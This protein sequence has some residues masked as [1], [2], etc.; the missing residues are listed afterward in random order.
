M[1]QVVLPKHFL[2]Y[3]IHSEQRYFTELSDT[4][5][6][7]AINA[8]MLAHAPAALA[9][10]V[11]ASIPDKVFVVDPLTHAFQHDPVLL[12]R[13]VP[14]VP[15]KDATL[16]MSVAKMSTEL[17]EPIASKAGNQ[18]VNP[19]DFDDAS[20]RQE[21]CRRVL[22]FQQ[23]TLDLASRDDDYRDYLD[24]A[25]M[26]SMRP[27]IVIAPYFFMK[28][29]TLD[30][31]LPLNLSLL[32][33]AADLEDPV[34]AQVVLGKDV[35]PRLDLIEKIGESYGKSRCAGVC[36][37]I[38]DLDEHEADEDVL[39]GLST[40]VRRIVDYGKSVHNVY[41]GY[42]SQ[43]LVKHGGLSGVCHGLEYGES[44]SVVP[45]GG[46]IP[47]AKYYYPPLH[48]RLKFDSL[49]QILEQ[50]GYD[51][52][53]GGFHEHVC[54]CETCVQALNGNIE[55]VGR[56]GE[57]RPVVSQRGGRAVTLSF[58]VPEA[59]DLCL[60]HYLRCKHAEFQMIAD[61]DIESVLDSLRMIA[62]EYAFLGDA[63]AFA[64]VWARVLAKPVA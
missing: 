10:F 47:I 1:G 22:L 24:Y 17:G 3:G 15:A 4:Y 51:E 34:H 14:G 60:R 58:P 11:G 37:W 20:T 29:N 42:F 25:E 38:D 56:F 5:E 13:K 64:D 50:T 23:Q 62:D 12:K 39:R 41:G 21:F 49:L 36:I 2:R 40:L 55:N 53:A 31:W 33:C 8:N 46:G 26:G 16:R 19:E 45:V 6:G 48:R 27:V 52:S 32:E 54:A 9:K 35:L 18:A 57:S 44:R 61:S 43:L 7:V 59:R 28:A 30:R 63:V